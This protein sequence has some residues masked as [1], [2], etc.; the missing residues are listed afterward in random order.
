ME[1]VIL[2]LEFEFASVIE[3]F[4]FFLCFVLL[5]KFIELLR[6]GTKEDRGFAIDYLRTS[7][8]PCA[9]NAYPVSLTSVFLIAFL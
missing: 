3:F 6:N 7:L 1:L 8:A 9:L 5:K 2:F 4:F